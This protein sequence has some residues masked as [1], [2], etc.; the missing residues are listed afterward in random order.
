MIEI[1]EV[2]QIG[3]AKWAELYKAYAGFY[4]VSMTQQQLQTA[5]GWLDGHE[6]ELRGLAALVDGEP[7][8]I[9]HYRRFLRPMA[10]EVGIF[11]DDIFVCPSAR[12][13]GVGKALL[14]RLENVA[15][16]QGCTVIR[17]ITAEDNRGAHKFYDQFAH[18]TSWVTYDHK[19]SGND[20]HEKK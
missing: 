13:K 18:K 6:T 17:W 19:M 4:K 11:L 9:I 3:F 16:A 1:V 20:G 12:R 8:G 10:G 7:Q 14:D 15:K 2:R 5:W